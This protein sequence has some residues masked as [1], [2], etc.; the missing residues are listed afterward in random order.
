MKAII[1][2]IKRLLAN[3]I[4]LGTISEVDTVHGLCRVQ[5][6]QNETDWLNW[7]TLRAG[8]V[9][10]WSAPSVGEQV[11]ILSI[12]GDFTTAF[13]LPAVFSDQNPAPSSSADAVRMEFPDGAAIEYEPET[14]ALTATGI[15]TAIIQA[16]ESITANTKVVMV[17][18]SKKITLD[19][20]VVECTNQLITASLLVMKGGEMQGEITHTGGSFKSNGVVIHTH[21]HAGVQTGG[22]TTQGPTS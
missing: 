13:V 7:L 18:A 14:G 17:T 10:F 8:R 1:A 3:I 2:E 12:S 5:I 16:S 22:G 9:R 6:G 20:P 15:K 11:I 21:K 4:R 19:T